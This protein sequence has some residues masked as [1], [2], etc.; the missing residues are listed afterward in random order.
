MLMLLVNIGFQPEERLE[1][2]W[3]RTGFDG[4]HCLDGA[5]MAF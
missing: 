3:E 4:C 2:H 5:N 1:R